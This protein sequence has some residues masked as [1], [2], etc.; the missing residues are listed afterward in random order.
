MMQVVTRIFAVNIV[1]GLLALASILWSGPA[2]QVF[3]LAGGA[4][5][6]AWL[7]Y[8]FAKGRPSAA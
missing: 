4:A 2:V 6:V 7:L 3:A 5:L 1:L 8:I